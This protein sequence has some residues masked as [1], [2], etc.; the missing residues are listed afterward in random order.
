MLKQLLV[1]SSAMLPGTELRLSIPLAFALGMSPAEAFGYSIAGNVVPVILLPLLLEKGTNWLRKYWIFGKLISWLFAW[2]ERRSGVISKYG[3][4]GL[5]LFVAIPMLGT[6]GWSGCIAAFLMRMRYKTTLLAVSAGMV[7]AG[8][9][10]TLACM[11][12]MQLFDF[13]R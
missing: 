11:G 5:I 12:V 4:G 8:V 9:V 6:G 7:I 2:I 3:Q 10:V 1:F 13:W